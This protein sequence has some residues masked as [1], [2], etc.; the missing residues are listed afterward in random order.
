M[1]EILFRRTLSRGILFIKLNT[2]SKSNLPLSIAYDLSPTNS[3]T[4][5]VYAAVILIGLYIM[6]IFEVIIPR[7]T[8]YRKIFCS[9][10]AS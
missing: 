10:C 9:E 8:K 2:N 7:E 6:I 1:I 4:N 3:D 5:I